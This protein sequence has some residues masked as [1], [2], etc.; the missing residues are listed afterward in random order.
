[1]CAAAGRVGS[2]DVT[3]ESGTPQAAESESAGR[4]DPG[5]AAE[6]AE[7][8]EWWD[9]PAMPWRHKPARA[10]VVCLSA[11]SFVAIYLLVMLPLRPVMLGLAPQLLGSLGH[12]TGFI[13]TG[14]LVAAGDRWWPLVLAVGSLM[15]IKFHWI[16]WW[17]G[18]LWGR[19]ILDTFAKNKSERTKRYYEKAWAVT[20]RFETLALIATF[21]PIPLPG[22]VIFAALGAAGTNLR[23][24]LTV[25]ILTSLVTGA[26]YMYLGYR[27]GEPAVDFMVAYSRYLW[28]VS[29]AI[30]VGMVGMAFW[31]AR[32]TP[33]AS[34]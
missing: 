34:E 1:M 6:T 7:P 4:V 19:E 33:T 11:L 32:R 21:L 28:Y 17:A 8:K 3:D 26:G 29:I 16:Y 15:M 31:R 14:A 20:H 25:C 30:I 24:F 13:M 2:S 9:D 12:W 5:A 18:R 23:K 22:G 27:L 10:D